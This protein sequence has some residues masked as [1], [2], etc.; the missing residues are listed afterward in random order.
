MASNR[1]KRKAA[2]DAE[3]FSKAVLI[4][5]D[6][7]TETDED[8]YEGHTA[9]R[10]KHSPAKQS[11]VLE[12]KPNCHVSLHLEQ[13]LFNSMANNIHNVPSFGQCSECMI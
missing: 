10:Q 6:S 8:M 7:E 11:H 1:P 2:V 13:I 4:K 3:G 12:E 9:K 5:S